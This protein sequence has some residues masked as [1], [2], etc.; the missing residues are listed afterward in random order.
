LALQG[1][2]KMIDSVSIESLETAVAPCGMADPTA[3]VIVIVAF[4]I[5]A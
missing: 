3:A 2:I 4:L 1:E 5:I